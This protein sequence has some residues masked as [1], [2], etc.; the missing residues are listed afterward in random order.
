M[1]WGLIEADY[2]KQLDVG[3][4]IKDIFV[5]AGGDHSFKR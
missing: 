3:L 1:T 5:L 4:E 2:S